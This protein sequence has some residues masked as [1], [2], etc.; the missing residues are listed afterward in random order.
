MWDMVTLVAELMGFA[1]FK[2]SQSWN[3]FGGATHNIFDYETDSSTETWQQEDIR[4]LGFVD[5][6]E[7]S[8][9]ER[10]EMNV[11]VVLRRSLKDP[12][13]TNCD[14]GGKSRHI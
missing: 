5:A 11:E 7:P 9:Q 13:P 8:P 3:Q 12:H 2:K 10:E 6:I 14:T 1:A 4:R